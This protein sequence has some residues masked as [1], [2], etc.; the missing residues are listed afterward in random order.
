[1]GMQ[2]R[3]WYRERYVRKP[4]A[5]GGNRGDEWHWATHVLVWLMVLG[6]AFLV[7]RTFERRTA[8]KQMPA[9][10]TNPAAPRPVPQPRQ[11][12]RP[13][14]EVAPAPAQAPVAPPRTMREQIVVSTIYL[15]QSYGGGKFWSSSHCQQSNALIDRM[16]T[17]P[18]NMP[19]EQQ[20]ALARQ[21][22][23]EAAALASPPPARQRAYTSQVAQ[24]SRQAQCDALDAEVRHWDSMARAP[25]SAQM[26]DW[27]TGKRK[28]ARDTQFRLRC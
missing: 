14:P 16:E 1:M 11:E 24:P 9:I 2:D 6:L 8:S 22:R 19:F 4:T 25:Q 17:V 28:I 20:V 5:R 26:Q 23:D 10:V 21:Q 27:I 3:D 7:F 15:C 18:S 12:P 13:R